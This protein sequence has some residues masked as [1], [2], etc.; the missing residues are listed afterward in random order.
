MCACYFRREGNTKLI[1][2]R[3]LRRFQVL[4]NYFSLQV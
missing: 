1:K 3:L 2:K 4:V